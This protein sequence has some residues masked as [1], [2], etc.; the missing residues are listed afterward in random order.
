[1]KL[2]NPLFYLLAGLLIMVM[3][4]KGQNAQSTDSKTDDFK[5]SGVVYGYV[6]ADYFTKLH[7]DS[8]N[9]GIKTQ[10]AGL[11]QNY[12]AFAFRRIY[13]GYDYQISPKFS[14][15]LTLA[16]ENDNLDASGQ[17]TLYIKYANLRWKNIFR[18]SDLILG[19]SA[20]PFFSQTSEVVW[21]YRNVEKTIADQRGIASSNDFGI[22]L[23]GKFNDKGDYGYHIMIANGTSQ[24]PEN[25][26]FKKLYG[27]VWAKFMDQ[28]LTIDLAGTTEA[29]NKTTAY[30]TIKGFVAYQTKPFTVGVEIVS[31]N[32]VSAAQLSKNADQV[33][34][35]SLVNVTPFGVSVFARGVLVANKVN[36]FARYDS[37]DPNSN[38]N[39]NVTYKT[40]GM[41]NYKE[42]FFTGGIDFTPHKNVHIIPNIWYDQSNSKLNNVSGRAKSDYDLVARVTVNY[43]FK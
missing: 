20:T 15:Q 25:N 19:Q 3:N 4:A 26:M 18:N 31:Q 34:D 9:R 38:F 16:N 10:Y 27:E 8:L 21:S 41:T 22:A 40:T 36:Y 42:N 33:A 28:K 43:I 1:M 2:K 6:Y 17:R 13:L 35:A 24:K 37:Y 39:A 14:T 7:A 23:Q 5:P 32:Q 30:N 29:Q 12:N 11:A